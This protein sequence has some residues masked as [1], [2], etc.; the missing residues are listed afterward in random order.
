M[1]KSSARTTLRFAILVALVCAA[2]AQDQSAQDQS[3]GDVARA[4]HQKKTSG[5]VID[6]EEMAQR[7]ARRGAGENALLCDA[8]CEA[9]VKV[10]VRQDRNLKM[11]DEQL[12]TAIAAGENELA[13][14]D[15]WSQLLSDIQ[16]QIC[17]KTAGAVDP[18]KANDLDRRVAKKLLD[19]VRKNM[20]I[21]S[22]AMDAGNNQ[23]AINQAMDASRAKAVKPHIFKVQVDRAKRMCTMST[24]STNTPPAN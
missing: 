22:H 13:Q 1:I 12:Q 4:Q 5:K 20:E 15:E 16:Q 3:L 23:A 24:S 21:I 18:V 10:A 7:R 2:Q 6:D 11:S 14:D 8:D 17:H 9:A 19:N